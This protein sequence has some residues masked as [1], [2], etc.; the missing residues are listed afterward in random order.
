MRPKRH[1]N[2]Q[3][4]HATQWPKP[5]SI[6]FKLINCKK[7]HPGCTRTRLYKP[8]NRKKILGEGAQPSRHTPPLGALGDSILRRST[9]APW[10]QGRLPRVSWGPNDAPGCGVSLFATFYV[11]HCLQ[12]TSIA[13]DSPI[14]PYLSWRVLEIKL[15]STKSHW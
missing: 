15:W 8:K 9:S 5:V 1:Q 6:Q 14:R 2:H 12:C 3:S 7:W 13:N 10:P 11:A 4:V